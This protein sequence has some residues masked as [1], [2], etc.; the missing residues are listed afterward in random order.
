MRL[1]SDRTNLRT[2]STPTTKRV[3]RNEVSSDSISSRSNSG[4]KIVRLEKPSELS[5]G[6]IK[7]K[8][9]NHKREKEE[10][11]K[12]AIADHKA[13]KQ[14]QKLPK[15]P[16]PTPSQEQKKAEV[17]EEA[18]KAEVKITPEGEPFGDIAKNDPKDP[19]TQEKLK[20]VL[21]AGAFNFSDKERDVL[22]KILNQ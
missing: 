5:R 7:A 9:E 17:I 4:Q 16:A 20:G 6:E 15:V 10:K 19:A 1:L 14:A 8:I 12:A 22:A 11:M 2:N 21:T 3:I 13:S 18:T